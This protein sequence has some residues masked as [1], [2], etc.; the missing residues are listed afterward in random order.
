MRISDWSS[1]VC[2][3]DLKPLVT[4]VPHTLRR[5]NLDTVDARDLQLLRHRHERDLTGR[6]HRTVI[7]AHIR[8]R[9]GGQTQNSRA[10][11]KA[12]QTRHENSGIRRSEEHTSELHSP[13]RN[14][15]AVF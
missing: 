12:D 14:S 9:T 10:A 7:Q 3:S 1:D 11:H 15:Y 13:M 8:A 6:P 2:S 5:G 4:L